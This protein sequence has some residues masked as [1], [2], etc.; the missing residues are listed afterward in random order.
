[1][2]RLTYSLDHPESH[3]HLRMWGSSVIQQRI[4]R[5]EYL[6]AWRNL[7]CTCRT[8]VIGLNIFYSWQNMTK[9]WAEQKSYDTGDYYMLVATVQ[10]QVII[11]CA[12]KATSHQIT[13]MQVTSKNV[14]FSGHNHLLT[15]GTD[16]LHFNYH[17]ILH[18]ETKH[19]SAHT[20]LQNI[21]VE[22]LN[23]NEWNEPENSD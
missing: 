11:H 23:N 18:R 8:Q 12:N 15:T 3:F 9:D 14:L 16:D 13:T 7:P 19:S 5:K 17:I 21:H 6:M 20:Q 22:Q 1:M 2:D 4:E 10:H